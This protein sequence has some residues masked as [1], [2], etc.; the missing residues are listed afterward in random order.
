MLEAACVMNPGFESFN[1]DTFQGDAAPKSDP[2]AGLNLISPAKAKEYLTAAD[3]DKYVFIDTRPDSFFKQCQIKG[4]VN[5]AFQAKNDKG[6][7][8]TAEIVKQYTD[9]GKI[10][11]FYCNALKCHRSLNAAIQTA[12]EWNIP[13]SQVKWFGEGVPGLAK[14]YKRGVAGTNCEQFY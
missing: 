13:A 12:C 11:V 10:V 2:S 4:A 1:K 14:L 7:L 3:K 5:H 8:L 6:N 9:K